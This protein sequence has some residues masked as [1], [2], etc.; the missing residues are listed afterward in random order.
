MYKIVAS[1]TFKLCLNRLTHF[2]ETKYSVEKSEAIKSSIKNAVLTNLTKDPFIAPISPR[3]IELGIKDYRQYL[4]DEYNIVFY[5]VVE[6]EK[7]VVL[8]AVMDARQSI[9]KLLQEVVLLS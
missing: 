5:R 8:L 6:K 9:Q 1:P 3:L 7:R 2:L 4:I